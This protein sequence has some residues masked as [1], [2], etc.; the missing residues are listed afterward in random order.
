MASDGTHFLE[1]KQKIHIFLKEISLHCSPNPSYLFLLLLYL[2]VM[3]RSPC[4]YVSYLLDTGLLL[5]LFN[6]QHCHN[7][8]SMLDFCW[9]GPKS[10]QLI[11]I[12]VVCIA[13]DNQGYFGGETESGPD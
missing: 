2:V 11:L 13:A 7:T 4:D 5:G 10:K 6:K 9:M 8:G 1:H 12:E 3:W